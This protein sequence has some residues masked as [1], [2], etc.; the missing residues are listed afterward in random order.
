MYVNPDCFDP[1]KNRSVKISFLRKGHPCVKENQ[2]F[3]KG[4][5]IHEYTDSIKSHV[6]VKINE[7]NKIN[8]QFLKI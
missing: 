6:S 3:L 1:K 4:V 8:E 5:P 7:T 2:N